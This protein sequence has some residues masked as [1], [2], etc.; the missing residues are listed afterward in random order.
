[1]ARNR[2][3]VNNHGKMSMNT[4]LEKFQRLFSHYLYTP[5][6]K[7]TKMRYEDVFYAIGLCSSCLTHWGWVMHMCISKLTIIGSDNGLLPG[8]L[9]AIIWTNAGILLLWPLETKFSETPIEINIFSFR[10]MHLK[11]LSGKWPTFCLS[12][13]VL[14]VGSMTCYIGP[15]CNESQQGLTHW[16]LVMHIWIRIIIGTG[17][18]LSPI[19]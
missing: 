9:Q 6:G 1:M 17:K 5:H 11:M 19:W 4:V 10:K 8:R 14:N 16:G 15:C 7:H 2:K 12:P 13:N 18:G 3:H